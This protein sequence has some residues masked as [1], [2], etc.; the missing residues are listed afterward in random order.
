MRFRQDTLRWVALAGLFLSLV[1]VASAQEDYKLQMIHDAEDQAQQHL[2]AG[3]FQQAEIQALHAIDLAATSGHVSSV[4]GVQ[5][6]GQVYIE[7]G[8]NKRAFEWLQEQYRPR[9][10]MFHSLLLGIAG[11]RAGNDFWKT[12]W[13]RYTLTNQLEAVVGSINNL[14]GRDTRE[15]VEASLLI[16]LAEEEERPVRLAEKDINNALELAPNNLAAIYVKA[17]LLLKQGKRG[18]AKDALNTIVP[19]T[20]GKLR[21]LVEAR[22]KL[23]E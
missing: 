1:S 15:H 10:D 20:S 2:A 19:K 6:A 21:G 11:L 17:G 9:K 8:E 13:A 23:A 14:P 7:Q 16:L 22:L 3:R 12:Q 18:E 5:I 4:R